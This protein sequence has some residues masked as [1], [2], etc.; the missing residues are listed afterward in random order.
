MK[1][2][3]QK[4]S[5][6]ISKSKGSL[7]QVIH[8]GAGEFSEASDYAGLPYRKLILIEGDPDVAEKLALQ[9]GDSSAATIVPSLITPEASQTGFHRYS[10]PF[11]NGPLALGELRRIYPRLQEL[12][13]LHR[14]GVTLGSFLETVP[15]DTEHQ[16]SLL[17]LDIPGQEGSIL[18]S[19]SENQLA[20]FEWILL[21][22]ASE[23]LQPGSR[24]ISMT[25]LFLETQGFRVIDRDE[26]NPQWP[27]LLF[28]KDRARQFEEK[29]VQIHQQGERIAELERVIAELSAHR[30]DLQGRLN[31][32]D[33][34]IQQLRASNDS[35]NAENQRITHELGEKQK[36]LDSM[37]QTR[38]TVHKS[39][40]SKLVE[41]INSLLNERDGMNRKI[42]DLEQIIEKE[43]I[44]NK[45]LEEGFIK[46]EGQI[47]FIKEIFLRGNLH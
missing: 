1:A 39:R 32:L 28:R 30:D 18:E 19:L 17:I 27:L 20:R 22:G 33:A 16:S 44:K 23:S 47:H 12:E 15:V 43:G 42:R 40:E 36:F 25:V 10:L 21:G 14:E 34:A 6:I 45:K 4:L 3:L 7:D 9:Y 38:E 41:Q 29:A 24:A 37:Y 46:T 5:T 35:L 26:S 11:L 31:E 13:K 2:F 8:L